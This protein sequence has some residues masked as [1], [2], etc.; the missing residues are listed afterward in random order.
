MQ[1]LIVASNDD[2]NEEVM[3]FSQHNGLRV[4]KTR[5]D[6]MKNQIQMNQML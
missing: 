6:G 5:H 4:Y 3:C 2:Q 1:K